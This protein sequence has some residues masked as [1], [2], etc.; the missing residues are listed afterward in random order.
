MQKLDVLFTELVACERVIFV[1][2][3]LGSKVRILFWQNKNLRLAAFFFSGGQIKTLFK[4][5]QLLS[6]LDIG[7]IRQMPHMR[8]ERHSKTGEYVNRN[9]VCLTHCLI[10]KLSCSAF[11]ALTQKN[12][13]FTTECKYIA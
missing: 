9:G 11:S 7:M 6:P 3:W 2:Y 1:S 13:T 8:T 4:I 12:D 5:N 10:E